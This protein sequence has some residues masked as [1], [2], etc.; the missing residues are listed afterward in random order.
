MHRRVNPSLE[1]LRT[2]LSAAAEQCSVAAPVAV[3]L[4]RHLGRVATT[5]VYQYRSMD[6]YIYL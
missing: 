5:Q 1:A 4:A 2:A 6:T 3:A